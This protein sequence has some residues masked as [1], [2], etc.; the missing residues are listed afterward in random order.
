MIQINPARLEKRGNL[1]V[2]T[3]PRVDRV[4]RFVVLVRRAGYNQ[5]RVRDN[6][7][8]IRPGL[9]HITISEARAPFEKVRNS[10]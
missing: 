2:A 9:M 3:R 7:I 1:G 10:Q 6:F 4:L 5:T 8:R